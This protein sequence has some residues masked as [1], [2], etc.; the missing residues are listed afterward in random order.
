[1]TIL[2]CFCGVWRTVR[3]AARF[4]HMQQLTIC[5]FAYTKPLSSWS[6]LAGVGSQSQCLT[7]KCRTLSGGHYGEIGSTGLPHISYLPTRYGKVAFSGK[8]RR[9]TPEFEPMWLLPSKRSMR[10]GS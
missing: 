7:T 10:F 5:Y 1:A 6:D 3:Q 8:M 2:I 9:A 4:L